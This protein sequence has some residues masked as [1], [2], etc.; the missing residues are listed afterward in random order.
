MLKRNMSRFSVDIFFVSQSQKT[1]QENPSELRLGK[2]PVANKF[3][4]EKDGGGG[5]SKL[6]A[7]IILSRSAEKI[8]R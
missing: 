3:V 1:L 5:A 7:E 8:L 4:D 6:S 2:F